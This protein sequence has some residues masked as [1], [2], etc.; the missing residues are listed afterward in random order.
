MKIHALCFSPTGG[1]QKA[2]QYLCAGM[3][4]LDAENEPSETLWT[5]LCQPSER[6]VYPAIDAD[7]WVVI[8]MPVFAGRV[9]SLAVK[10]L[11]RTTANHAR[12]ILLAVYGNRAVDDALVEM[13]D[14]AEALGFKVVAAVAAVAEHSIARVYATGRPDAEDAEDLGDIGAEIVH[15]VTE[16][17]ASETLTIPGNRPYRP[18]GQGPH[19]TADDSCTGCGKCSKACPAGAISPE[20]LRGV[21][22]EACISC[23]RC[24]SVCPTHARNIGPV[25]AMVTEKLRPLCTEHKRNELFV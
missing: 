17:T 13:Q 8:S 10:N 11:R 1:T 15:R 19:P 25:T 4:W 9:P 22:P 2:T 21:N 12:C 20:D 18:A 7:D 5:D 3:H 6:I 14:V 24:V 16:G 23:M